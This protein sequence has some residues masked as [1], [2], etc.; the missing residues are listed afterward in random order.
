MILTARLIKFS[1]PVYGRTRSR[2]SIALSII[3][4]QH[5]D[6]GK[7]RESSLVT[8]AIMR[9]HDEA[10]KLGKQGYTDPTSGLFVFTS[11]EAERR[12]VC[13]GRKCRHCPY[14]VSLWVCVYEL[15]YMS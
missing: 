6:F 3:Y 8:P 13:C 9:I 11:L 10:V 12:G 2:G 14:M 1:A 4:L 5:R 7:V 15:M